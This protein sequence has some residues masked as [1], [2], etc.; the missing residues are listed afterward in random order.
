MNTQITF[1][2]SIHEAAA[3]GNY[4][5][6]QAW[7]EKDIAFAD[8][9]DGF[10][11]TPLHLAAKEGYLSIVQLL[12]SHDANPCAENKR[13]ATPLSVVVWQVQVTEKHN[14]IVRLFLQKGITANQ[15]THSNRDDSL[16]HKAAELGHTEI[17]RLFLMHG[18]DPNAVNEHGFPA[19]YVDIT[20]YNPDIIATFLKHP[21]INLDIHKTNNIESVIC[22]I[23]YHV[24][25]TSLSKEKY[26]NSTRLVD[27]EYY[28]QHISDNAQYIQCLKYFIFRGVTLDEQAIKQAC[29]AE[30]INTV[31]EDFYPKIKIL[32]EEAFSIKKKGEEKLSSFPSVIAKHS[33]YFLLSSENERKAFLKTANTL[34]A[35]HSKNSQTSSFFKLPREILDQIVQ[36]RLLG[37]YNFP[38]LK[39]N[40]DSLDSK[41]WQLV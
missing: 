16:L 28:E 17:V 27:R 11:N 39:H 40:C 19:W 12:L 29:N 24:K 18:A 35:H 9:R 31:S 4:A 25:R 22:S 32:I 1:T 33:K 7:L 37:D 8:S 41:A 2:L 38:N 13:R 3:Q 6:V 5:I 14:Q 34:Y 15:L 10:Q 23:V 21:N 26:K 30:F 36:D 20:Q